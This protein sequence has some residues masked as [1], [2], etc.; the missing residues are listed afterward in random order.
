MNHKKYKPFTHLRRY[1]NLE[2]ILPF[3][4]E[5][6]KTLL[7]KIHPVVRLALPFVFVIPFLIIENVYLIY[8]YILLT[9]I[10]IL[11]TRLNLV[12]IIKRLKSVIP[13]IL[14]ITIFLPL[15][16]GETVIFQINLGISINI[17]AEGL[18][19]A[20]FLFMRIFGATFIFM[21]FFSSLTY[22]EFIEALTSIKLPA[23]FV[24]SFIIMLHY[25][26]IIATSNKKILEAQELR[27]K[28]ITSYWQRLKVHAFIMGKSLVANMERSE[29]LY[30]SLKMRG[31]SGELTFAPRKIKI[32]DLILISI[33]ILIS[34]YL[35]YF[36]NLE[37]IY[38]E[39]FK[40]FL[41]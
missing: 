19:R 37:S 2:S 35:I 17:Y 10:F 34:V 6:E 23:F 40:L 30:E 5:D 38:A 9:L 12:R 31:F 26:P 14:L 41:L 25:I 21:S 18:F 11:I 7:N 15:Y 39:V 3:R 36:L 4:H 28:K 1:S 29:R 24:G 33:F 8:S 20:F 16:I 32:Y 22:S 27:G 13:F